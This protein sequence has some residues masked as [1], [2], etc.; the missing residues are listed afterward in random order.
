MKSFFTL[1]L[2]L[3][4]HLN[5]TPWM[6]HSVEAALITYQFSG[7]VETMSAP[8]YTLGGSGADGFY[9]G[10]TLTG[11]YTFDSTTP[12]ITIP[13]LPPPPSYATGFYNG[14]IKSLGFSLG[15]YASGPQTVGNNSSFV[16]SG[17]F[18]Q[19]M[20]YHEV[21]GPTVNGVAPS[22]FWFS[23]VDSIGTAFSNLDL[24]GTEPPS[25]GKFDTHQWSFVFRDGST[26]TGSLN[27]LQ[28][29]PLPSTG[30]LFVGALI[31]L[32]LWRMRLSGALA[33]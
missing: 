15:T 23:V 2:S 19:Y 31:G 13:S 4:V 8:I 14:S 32:A 20:M 22:Y 33:S 17:D 3:V 12:M 6:S 28:P 24:P 1:V 16:S 29:V 7:T 5:L 25:I 18:S 26:V 21:T 10:L 27:S 9:Y 30:L 11:R